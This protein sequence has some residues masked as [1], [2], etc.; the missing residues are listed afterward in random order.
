MSTT[1][2]FR[3][4][5]PGVPV[6]ARGARAMLALV[7]AVSRIS[8][9]EPIDSAWQLRPEFSIAGMTSYA[10]DGGV[11]T[12]HDIV[13]LTG[14]LKLHSEARPYYGGV[15]VNYR[16]STRE[17][18]DE[19]L[20][21]GA[22]VRVNLSRW[23][24]TTWLFVNQAPGRGDTWLYAARLRYRVAERYKLGVEALAPVER[25]NAPELM[26]GYYGSLTKSLSLN[27]LAGTG[28]NGGPDRLAR[29]ELS[30]QVR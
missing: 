28:V 23:D 3:G 26:L 7:L 16:G 19:N 27:V 29:M 21:L 25:A 4:H 30:W 11:A 24:A 10:S 18:F 15:F 1:Q 14:E 6:T 5:G 8:G 2:L 9:A 17:R 12:N 20:N 22:Y 13:S